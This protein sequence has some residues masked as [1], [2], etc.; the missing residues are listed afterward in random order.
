MATKRKSIIEEALLEAKSLEDALKANTKEILASHMKE[1][2]ETIVESS[3]K[4]QEDEELEIDAEIEG[5]DEEI[6]EPA[7]EEAGGDL[8]LADEIGDEESELVNLDIDALSGIDDEDIDIDIAELP[9]DLDFGDGTEIDLTDQSDEEV[10]KVFKAMGDEDEVEVVRDEDG[11]TLTDNETGAEYY[12]K[13]SEQ[14]EEDDLCEGCGENVY[15]IELDEEAPY[16]GNKGDESESDRDYVEEHQGYDDEE[17][18]SLGMRRGPERRYRQSYKDRREDSY[19]KW[20]KRGIEDRN[21]SLE[22]DQPYGG[23]KGDESE[24][25]RDYVEEEHYGG[26][27]GDESRSRRDYMEEDQPYGGNK[28]DESE[29]DRDYVEEDRIRRHQKDGYQR[30]S[31]A[32]VGSNQASPYG[33]RYN[34]SKKP[35]RTISGKKRSAKNNS[36]VPNSTIL[37]EYKE[38]KTKN[39]EYKEALQ[40]FKGKLNEVALFNTNLAYVN[41][42]FTEHSTTKKEKMNILKRFDGA[43]SVKESKSIYKTIKSELGEKAPITESVGN[44]VNKTV[45]SAASNLNESTAYVDPQIVAIKDLMKRIS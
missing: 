21:I 45:K 27:K 12:I 32:K 22:E 37:K 13:E 31:G 35:R 24:S 8:E 16:G 15:E 4:E 40:L 1:E 41:R 29:S 44:K 7:D 36:Q 38:L 3:L 6:E 19:G 2:I 42:L 20:G 34:E 17:D 26:N 10:L 5:S 14:L 23:N 11:I 9:I 30:R 18:E 43:E 28:G 39:N 25:D 33:G